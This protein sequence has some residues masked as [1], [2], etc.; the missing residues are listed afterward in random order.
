LSTQDDQ[1]WIDAL[2]GRRAVVE[3][4]TAQEAMALRRHFLTRSAE[5]EHAVPQ[6]DVAREN[7]LI[8]RARAAGLLPPTSTRRPLSPDRLVIET[9]ARR[10][11][12]LLGSRWPLLAAAAAL[13]ILAVSISLWRYTLPQATE[14]RGQKQH[15]V[16]LQA[17]NPAAYRN[18]LHDELVAAGLKVTRYEQ[19]GRFGIDADL[20][21]PLPP[22]LQ[23]ILRGFHIPT[24]ADGVL[25]VE[26]EALQPQ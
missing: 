26:I 20:P 14:E 8:E 25:A 23:A 5:A 22:N 11:R 12:N 17:G 6:M 21:Q 1:D 7:Q 18:Q 4:A 10:P 19:L 13:A 2:A 9:S 3:S 24:P 16:R 15:V